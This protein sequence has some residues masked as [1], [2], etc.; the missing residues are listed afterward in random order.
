MVNGWLMDFFPFSQSLPINDPP[1]LIWHAWHA[2]LGAEKKSFFSNYSRFLGF[3]ANLE[4]LELPEW[5][6]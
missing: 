6:P 4:T 5:L 3:L 1:R 2:H